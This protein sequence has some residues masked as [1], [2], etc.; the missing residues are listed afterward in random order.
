M[1]AAGAAR[2]AEPAVQAPAAEAAQPASTVRLYD[3]KVNGWP[4]GMV[5]RFY[6]EDGRLSLPA[7]QYEGLGFKPDPATVTVVAGEPRVYLDQVAGLAWTVN[8]LD[9]SIDIK[10]PFDRL[11]RQRIDVE[12]PEARVQ[13]RADWGAMLA[14]DAFLEWAAEPNSKFFGRQLTTNLDA[15]LFSPSFTART[16]AFTSLPASG[17]ARIVRLETSI[18]FDDPE[19]M[20]RLRFGDS[21]TE[22]MGGLQTMRFA[23]VQWG[24]EH[25]LR[26]D[27]ITTPSPILPQNVAVPSTLD[28]FINGVKRYSQGLDPGAFDVASLP[29]S[30]GRNTVQVVVTDQAGRR[31]QTVLPLYETPN[32]L[33]QGRTEFS[34][35]AG[36]ARENYALDSFDYAGGFVSGQ[37]EHG[38]SDR[39]TV[40]GHADFAENYGFGGAGVLANLWN[41]LLVGGE[42]AV[43]REHGSTGFGW[44]AVLQHTTE[45]FD[46]SLSYGRA[47]DAYRDLPAHFGYVHSL[48]KITASAGLNLGQAGHINVTYARLVQPGDVRSEVAS[49]SYDVELFHHF[50]HLS[51]TGYA[52]LV[53]GD[54]GGSLS[55]TVP[56]GKWGRMTAEATRDADGSDRMIQIQ[57]EALQQRLEWEA[58]AIDGAS[59]AASLEASWDGTHADLYG[60]LARVR[61]DDGL[62][63]EVA[64]SLVF[65]DGKLFVA[66]RVDDAFTVVDSG[67]PNIRVTLENRPAGRTDASGRIL[68]TDLQ[69][70][71][72]NA[73]ALNLQDLPLDVQAAKPS[74]LVAPRQGAGV[75]TRF[76]THREQAAVI[77]LRLADGKAPPLGA[78]VRLAGG[79]RSEVMGYDGEVYVRDLP[80]GPH[81]LDVIWDEGKCQTA[82]TAPQSAGRLPKLGPFTC[83]P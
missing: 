8:E 33:A 18:D 70:Y 5:A 74:L 25:A 30:A 41:W 32:L 35:A 57:G 77:T 20:R 66:G 29:T 58:T 62:Q 4:R 82:F 73:V 59:R 12:A 16:T 72:G 3:V 37:V 78:D 11:Q 61:G 36:A 53:G 46:V 67:V 52:D 83:A 7:D 24:T 79:K 60:R 21:L 2:A 68:L 31:I 13:S 75:I 64:Q 65:M 51:A 71:V 15:R 48:E 81:T 39:I 26:P 43:S 9:Q 28:V 56:L 80:P 45:N 38:L 49:A 17:E 14:Y 54:W 10:T 42:A 6:D 44:A 63:A 1:A 76:E 19:N 50:I 27:I 34:L 40:Q 23:G 55:L 22:T 47:N 69:S